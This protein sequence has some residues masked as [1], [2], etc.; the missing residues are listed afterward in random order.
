M[1]TIH[2]IDKINLYCNVPHQECK[3]SCV[4]LLG[5][6]GFASSC[7]FTIGFWKSSNSTVFFSFY[8]IVFWAK[9]D[10]FYNYI[11]HILPQV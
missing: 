5:G 10:Q 11:D 6:I 3:Q 1:L 4:C 8:V 7:D 2:Y 9:I